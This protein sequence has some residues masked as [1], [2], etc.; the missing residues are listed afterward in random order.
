MGAGDPQGEKEGSR[1]DKAKL[2]GYDAEPLQE[3]ILCGR[4]RSEPLPRRADPAWRGRRAEGP[5]GD[6]IQV[7]VKSETIL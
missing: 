3:L 7:E 5:G 2:F 1:R 4:H 6:A